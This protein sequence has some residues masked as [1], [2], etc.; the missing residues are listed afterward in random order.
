MTFDN[1]S[2]TITRTATHFVV[3]T[4]TSPLSVTAGSNFLLE[5][6]AEDANGNLVPG[7]TGTVSFTSSDSTEAAWLSQY[8]MTFEPGTGVAFALVSLQHVGTWS[9]TATATSSNQATNPTGTS[10]V[11]TD[12]ITVTNGSPTQVAIST[13]ANTYA[14]TTIPVS[15]TLEDLYGNPVLGYE[16]PATDTPYTVTLTA[17]A[18]SPSTLLFV[19]TSMTSS[20]P[21]ASVDPTTGI[22]TFSEV[23]IHHSSN[24]YYQLTATVAITNS[25]GVVIGNLGHTSDSFTV[26]PGVATHLTFTGQPLPVVAGTSDFSAAVSCGRLLRQRGDR[27]HLQRGV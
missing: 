9:I 16:Y 8:T 21:T 22:A 27:R 11:V 4:Q 24:S 18:A 13:I 7:Y 19:G 10:N 1:A 15:A 2:G 5:L 25:S 12:G 23:N 20:I 3:T 26:T 6:E 17:T 14:G